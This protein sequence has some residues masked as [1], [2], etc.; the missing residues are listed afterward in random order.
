MRQGENEGGEAK[1]RYDESRRDQK[2]LVNQH[3][4]TRVGPKKAGIL[5]MAGTMV[6]LKFESY[7]FAQDVK[8]TQEELERRRR[9]T[10]DYEIQIA[11]AEIELQKLTSQSKELVR[12]RRAVYYCTLALKWDKL[13]NDVWTL[14]QLYEC[15]ETDIE[16]FRISNK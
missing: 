11:D 6:R 13:I 5:E 2:R 1:F 10:K 4:S 16:S 3:Y 9:E 15:V 14:G 12:I 7:I 8:K